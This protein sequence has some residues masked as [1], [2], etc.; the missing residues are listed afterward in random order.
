MNDAT[1]SV[2]QKML[3]SL[4]PPIAFALGSV[5]I[6]NYESAETGVNGANAAIDFDNYSY[7]KCVGMLVFDFVLYTLLSV[8]LMRVIPSEW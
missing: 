6:A 3:A 2:G 8:Y 7:D 4:S 1:S 5:V